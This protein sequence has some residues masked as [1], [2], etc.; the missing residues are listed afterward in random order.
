MSRSTHLDPLQ[1][2]SHERIGLVS[3]AA[4]LCLAGGLAS[5]AQP[6]SPPQQSPSGPAPSGD[7]ESAP[8]RALPPPGATNNGANG[9]TAPLPEVKVTATRPAPKRAAVK[10]NPAPVVQAA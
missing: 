4:L 3:V 8:P 9:S 2:G 7:N 6:A 5:S 1:R 10:R